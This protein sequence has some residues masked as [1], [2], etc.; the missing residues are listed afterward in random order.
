MTNSPDIETG[1][2]RIR[3]I[4]TAAR[5]KAELRGKRSP[6]RWPDAGMPYE[7]VAPGGWRT[8]GPFDDTSHLPADCPV[9][10]LGYDGERRFFVDTAGQIFNSDGKAMGQERM[11]LLFSGHEGFLVWAWPRFAKGGG[12]DSFRP[13]EARRDLYAACYVRGPWNQVEQVRGRGA[14]LDDRGRLVLHCGEMLYIPADE[15][16][17]QGTGEL[18]EHF[19]VSRPKAIEP[20]EHP[21][22]GDDNPAVAIIEALRSWNFVRGDVDV[23]LFLGWIGVALMGAALDWRPSI[24]IVGDAG[25]G[26]SELNRLLKSILGRFMVTTTNATSAGLYQLVGHDALAIGIDELEGDDGPA[27]AEQII[28]MAR[29][30]ASGSTRI[31]GGANHQ[32]VEFQ[33]RSTFMFS[34]INPP[35]I[36]P[37]SMSRLALLQLRPLLDPAAS[38][39]TLPDVETIGPKLLRRVADHWE[40]FA[41]L[42]EA[43]RT[44]L[45]ENGH[46]SRGQNTFGT[47]LA[48]AH[49]LLGD[50]GM[51]AVGLPWEDLYHW[52]RMLAADAAPE[53]SDKTPNWSKCIDEILTSQVDSWNKGERRTIGQIL[54]DLHD[55]ERNNMSLGKANELLAI[56]GLKLLEKGLIGDGYALCVPI[57][58]KDINKLMADSTWGG[59]GSDGSWRWALAQAPEHIVHKN[60]MAKSGR[61]NPQKTENRTRIGGVQ[62]RC[63]FISLEDLRKWQ[64]G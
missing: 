25:G 15:N 59:R 36:P 27:Q 24:F 29:D 23:M 47:F 54:E 32:G 12:V 60:F 16:R 50:E 46:A 11:Q 41:R 21:V 30:A 39:P 1:T 44:T 64:E 33:A 35:P 26:K 10:P 40:D 51:D 18:G 22:E 6:A 63:L 20:Y 45:R 7:G 28:K 49:L 14:W 62:R 8:K 56:A 58:G 2:R 53:V 61:G 5:Q 9:R 19:Y 4:T 31:R 43:Y 42:Y 3:A 48:A 55:N 57:A 38:V 17:V 34:A 13:E 37:A 52:G